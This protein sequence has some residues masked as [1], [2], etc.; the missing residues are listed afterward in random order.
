MSSVDLNQI[1]TKF[2]EVL[3][4]YF[5]SVKNIKKGE[6]FDVPLRIDGSAIYNPTAV[7]G[8]EHM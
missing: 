5:Y 1:N 3:F 8:D 4:T 7:S 2:P 6:L